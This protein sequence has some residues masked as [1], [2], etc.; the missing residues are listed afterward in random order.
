MIVFHCRQTDQ[1][2]PYK[3]I[4]ITVFIHF[5]ASF[6]LIHQDSPDTCHHFMY[7]IPTRL[8]FKLRLPL[9]CAKE[10]PLTK[11]GKSLL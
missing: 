6:P 5:D 3:I 9:V 1:T 8:S 7:Q 4:L 11:W 10:N 2:F